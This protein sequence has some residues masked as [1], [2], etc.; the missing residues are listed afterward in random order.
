M[1]WLW[2]A[3]AITTEVA[4]TVALRQSVGLS[5]PLPVVVVVLGY[6]L[7]FWFLAQTLRHIP[8]SVTYAVWSALGTT[9]IALIGV[10]AFGEEMTLVRAVGVALVIAG[11]VAI[12]LGAG[13]GA[14]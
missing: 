14:A 9:A 10:V 1:G 2:L 12:N 3:G 5:R 11:V 13:A 6:A 4:G 8:L 7:S